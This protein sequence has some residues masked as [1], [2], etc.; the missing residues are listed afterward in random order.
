MFSTQS[1]TVFIIA[2]GDAKIWRSDDYGKEWQVESHYQG[3][4]QSF[5]NGR[6]WQS[7]ELPVDSNYDDCKGVL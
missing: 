7:A 3:L 1:E 6:T 5:D 4:S 2:G